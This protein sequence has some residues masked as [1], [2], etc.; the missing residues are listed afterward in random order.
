MEIGTFAG[1]VAYMRE[2]SGLSQSELA[3][4]IGV[5]PQTI[6]AIEAGKVQRSRYTAAIARKLNVSALWLQDGGA[7]SEFYQ[8]QEFGERDRSLPPPI[9][10]LVYGPGSPLPVLEMDPAENAPRLTV[11]WVRRPPVLSDEP[12]AF[13]AIV[14]QT[15][16]APMYRN[17]QMVLVR[18]RAR[19]LPD[20]GI[21]LWR[22][23]HTYMVRELIEWADKGSVRVL[24][25]YP[26]PII[27]LLKIGADF[28]SFS[29][30][31]GA[32]EHPSQQDGAIIHRSASM[33]SYK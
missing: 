2:A 28:L 29:A 21:L 30:I 11:C 3:R 14:W 10:E 12:H 8:F 4:S 27:E 24:R 15:D 32:Q 1:R 17:R 7:L 6:Q 25:Y 33:V 31:V 18:P 5:T 23:D 26:E 22:P 9:H 20:R 19:A 16:M 13:G